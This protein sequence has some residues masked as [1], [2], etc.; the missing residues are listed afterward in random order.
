MINI[1]INGLSGKMGSS[2]KG[3]LD[4]NKDFKLVPQFN[5]NNF[6]DVVIDFSRPES[7]IGMLKELSLIHI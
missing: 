2:L 4:K 3:L 5:I 1:H 7:S 6:I